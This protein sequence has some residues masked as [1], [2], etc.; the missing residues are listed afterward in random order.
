M[1]SIY[2]CGG[3]G[4]SSNKTETIIEIQKQQSTNLVFAD[5]NLTDCVQALIDSE[6]Y[7]LVEQIKQLNCSDKSI[8][9]IEGIQNLSSL[10]LLNL[11]NNQIRDITPISKLGRLK[12]L[13][14]QGNNLQLLSPVTENQLLEQVDISD[15]TEIICS[16]QTKLEQSIG[17]EN[18][19]ANQ[20]C[21]E[22]MQQAQDV[23]FDDTNLQ[24]CIRQAAQDIGAQHLEQIQQLKCV[25]QT[26]S[27][28]SGIEQLTNLRELDLTQN[29]II[30][31]APLEDL[32]L[33]KKVLLG[34]NQISNI[35][36]LKTSKYMQELR[37][38]YNQITDIQY[39]QALDALRQIH[40]TNNQIRDLTPLQ[41]LTK[42][43]ELRISNNRIIDIDSLANLPKLSSLWIQGNQIADLT[44]LQSLQNLEQL[45][46][47]N[48]WL[49]DLTPLQTQSKLKWLHLD[50]TETADL[51]PL[52]KLTQLKWLQLDNTRVDDI[53]AIYPLAQ[54]DWLHLKGNNTIPCSQL[55]HM[56]EILTAEKID[57]PET[58]SQ[59]Q[60]QS[61]N[62]ISTIEFQD[63]A[64][65]DCIYDAAREQG[66]T[67]AEELTTLSCNSGESSGQITDITG[68]EQFPGITS[69]DLSGN[70]HIACTQL[71]DLRERYDYGY[72]EGEYEYEAAAVAL[73][74][75]ESCNNP[76]SINTQTEQTVETGA[77][78]DLDA[79]ATDPNGD[80]L[81]YN[82]QQTAGQSVQLTNP[83]TATP[84]FTAPQGEDQTITFQLTVTDQYGLSTTQTI[85]ILVTGAILGSKNNPFLV[86]NY[87]DLKKVG[88]GTDGWNLDSYYLQ[89]ADIDATPSKT[90][91]PIPDTEGEYYGF[92]PIGTE[93]SPFTG[94]YDGGG[95][96]IDG[97]TINRSEQDFVGL[98]GSAVDAFIHNINQTNISVIG[99]NQVGGIVGKI[100]SDLSN[101]EISQSSISGSVKGMAY[102]GC[103][104][105]LI[106]A[107]QVKIVD[108]SVS[109]DVAGSFYVGGLAGYIAS[110]TAVID[111]SSSEGTVTGEITMIGGL[112][113]ELT[114]SNSISINKSY[115]SGTIYVGNN[116]DQKLGGLFGFIG[117]DSISL[118][119]SYSNGDIEILSEQ[120]VQAIGGIIGYATSNNQLFIKNC[121]ADRNINLISRGATS[122]GGFAGSI[123][124][125]DG[126]FELSGNV[127]AGDVYFDS[128]GGVSLSGGFAGTIGGKFNVS[129]NSSTG[130]IFI[131]ENE[132]THAQYIGGHFGYVAGT[133]IISHSFATGNIEVNTGSNPSFYIGGFSG[134]SV[135]VDLDKVRAAGNL[136]GKVTIGGLVGLFQGTLSESF[137]TG[138]VSGESNIGGLV[139]YNKGLI[140]NS[141]A[142]GNVT[143]NSQVGGLV[144]QMTHSDGDDENPAKYSSITN[145]YSTGQILLQNEELEPVD[146]GGL[147]GVSSSELNT[148]SNSFWDMETSGI[149]TSAGGEPKTSEQLKTTTTF[150]NAG[151]DFDDT[152][153]IL[154]EGHT[155]P[156][157]AWNTIEVDSWTD[158][159]NMRNNLHANYVLTRDLLTTD[160]DYAELAGPDANEGKGWKPVGTYEGPFGGTFGGSG[161]TIDGL[162][163][164]RPEEDLIGM[165][166]YAVNADY[167]NIFLNSP[168]VLG[169]DIVGSFVGLTTGSSSSVYNSNAVD[170]VVSG[171]HIVGGLIGEAVGSYVSIANSSASSQVY[172]DTSNIGGL[173]GIVFG[174][175]TSS[176][177]QSYA[178]GSVEGQSAVGGLAGTVNCS[179]ENSYSRSDVKAIDMVGGLIGE[180]RPNYSGVFNVIINSYSN[181][182]VDGSTKVGG[183]VGLHDGYDIGEVDIINSFWDI[184]TSG[185]SAKSGGTGLPTAEMQTRLT[186]T[187]AGWDFADVW[188]MRDY[189]EFQ[190]DSVAISSIEFIDAALRDCV[191]ETAEANGWAQSTQVTNL[192]CSDLDITDITGLEQL[193]EI[194]DLDLIGNNHISCNQLDELQNNIGEQGVNRPEQCNL[195]PTI[196]AEEQ[197]VEAGTQV[198]LSAEVVDPN[199]DSLTYSWKQTG[200]QTVELTNADTAVA[201]FIAPE[202]ADQTLSFQLTA[203]DPYGLSAVESINIS[204]IAAV[205]GTKDNPFLVTSYEDLKKVG[206][207]IDGWNLDSHYLQ[208]ADI[209]ASP[210]KTENL[211]PETEGEYYGF[212]PIG[213]EQTPFTGGY[214]GGMFEI[215]GLTIRAPGY[216]TGLFGYVVSGQLNSISLIDVDIQGESFVAG[217]AG[218]IIDQTEIELC[219]VNGVI[220]GGSSVGGIAGLSAGSII[221]NCN[222]DVNIDAA[223]ESGGVVG[224][225]S[226]GSVYRCAAKVSMQSGIGLVGG[227]AGTA[228]GGTTQIFQSYAKGRIVVTEENGTSAG[229]VIGLLQ[230]AS[231]SQSYFIGD[232]HAAGEVGG[233]VGTNELA[234]T[235]DNSYALGIVEAGVFA[236]GLV[237]N[238][239]SAINIT[240][241]YASVFV[242]ADS[243]AGGLIGFD[244]GQ[245]PVTNSFWNTETSKLITSDGGT[246]QS[247]DQMQARHIYNIA[248]WD[249]NNVWR[250]NGKQYP[251]LQWQKDPIFVTSYE[252]LKKIGNDPE[253]P[254]DGHYVQTADI[255]AAVSASEN[256]IEGQAGG[257]YGFMPI[258]YPEIFT[259]SYD[260]AGF[261][262]NDLYINR[263]NNEGLFAYVQNAY[264]ANI[265]LNNLVAAYDGGSGWVAGLVAYDIRSFIDNCH[266]SL[267]AASGDFVGGIAAFSQESIVVNSSTDVDFDATRAG[268][269]IAYAVKSMIVNNSA[270][271]VITSSIEYA[272]GLV[273]S[274][275]SASIY[276]CDADVSIPSTSAATSGGL[277]GVSDGY[278]LIVSSF[279]LGSVTSNIWGGGLVGF[280][281]GTVIERSYATGNV[282]SEFSGGL[283]GFK[284]T[285]EIHKSYASGNVSG[286]GEGHG[287]GG[288]VGA[289]SSALVT[290]SYAKGDVS[291]ETSVAGLIGKMTGI[292]SVYDSYSTGAVSSSSEVGGL[293]AIIEDDAVVNNSFWDIETSGIE[294]SAGGIGLTTAEMQTQSTFTDAEWDFD[295]I[296]G[297]RT[298][299]Y[300]FLQWQKTI[301]V[302]SYEDLKK[303][304]VL[305]DWPLDGNYV[306]LA[307]IDASPSRNENDGQGFLPI[308]NSESISF[309]GSYD[310]SGYE[311]DSIYINRPDTQFVGLFGYCLGCSIFN[312]NITD[313]SSIIGRDRTGGLVGMTN[314]YYA[315]VTISNS[316]SNAVVSSMGDDWAIAGGLIGQARYHN[317][318]H[319]SSATGA[320][321]GEDRVGGLIGLAGEGSTTVISKCY[322]TGDIT[323]VGYVGGLIG[324]F[325]YGTL[326]DSYATGNVTGSGDRI[327][328]LLG[329]SGSATVSNSYSVGGVS[330]EMD[331]FGGMIGTVSNSTITNSFW[332]IESSGQETSAGG[333][334]L[335]TFEMQNQSSYTE[336]DFDTIWEI[337]PESYPVLQ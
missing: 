2:A 48:N 170:A 148:V 111:N 44:P 175:S 219:S 154:S 60:E 123:T 247:T 278:G 332:D 227:I 281:T 124:S 313:D 335:T 237:G 142:R 312:V 150:T 308:G 316:T 329:S 27:N 173:I 3:G 120:V 65:R 233:L 7:T 50:G 164:N 306:Q 284:N 73:T 107:V 129:D 6:D 289:L 249:F 68:L 88:T 321:S 64:L 178:A 163:I 141:Y 4:E 197:I 35:Q 299:D 112:V 57:R 208:T 86:T 271:G 91:N 195:P 157:L 151:W 176:I 115:S 330:A 55:D 174:E 36:P 90:E 51:Q 171:R 241:S 98:F 242:A 89:T 217:V 326:T 97:L 269:L 106:D 69:I 210:S 257:Y 282:I 220:S 52:N 31:I 277:V 253:W 100:S 136:V 166:G 94:G 331:L 260:G 272:G 226:A 32:A 245:S 144:G 234:A 103:I 310:G 285:G 95:F 300:P 184:E 192:N 279:S 274:M 40:L 255:D 34:K 280:D 146:F 201:T 322:A 213:T 72:E 23:N 118:I 37:L 187:D 303:I 250:M 117:G 240:N 183:L 209:D 327:G 238:G 179:V 243:Q 270:K 263:G 82:W 138:N 114:G 105:G 283:I 211:I 273:G 302:T 318:I 58:C 153:M 265:I 324:A 296:W 229:G 230:G 336:W 33:L 294:V 10:E 205:L 26:I 119:D 224:N 334:G 231:I 216:F 126:D 14:L 77:Q 8:T 297:Y 222:V 20:P 264:L 5:Q 298:D 17:E 159:N 62:P 268:G 160:A 24:A 130:N 47:S 259:G 311:I 189:P 218:Y 244:K 85:N 99:D 75:P 15:N 333:I 169:H 131:K 140:Y 181:G 30:D 199:G 127:A 25:N 337:A 56:E 18:L 295:D 49:T 29:N 162:N 196:S 71:D 165:F 125:N 223:A 96:E 39:V 113:G 104:S 290:N 180:L 121:S 67:N 63:Q 109:C 19:T 155:Y 42:L 38:D 248:G 167:S 53:T 1:L 214:N 177:I 202:E 287:I 239:Y 328:G 134:V 84:S 307:D 156:R 320:V 145:S 207:G 221:Q 254:L 258:G 149:E 54:L 301:Y 275:H 252:D 323:G 194:T 93:E 215:N 305:E 143:G 158:L 135:G 261:S 46:L 291:G 319:H 101:I 314:G 198:N 83:N 116:F 12:Q 204:V 9:D 200:G 122:V 193:T 251:E 262:I 267:N 61:G 80:S 276:F 152:W 168:S 292:A 172:G 132:E 293:V 236:G 225:I 286:N 182:T 76:P 266:V 317:N 206:T 28:I 128:N 133:G 288:L 70:D 21:I 45:W 16:E 315:I 59:P 191:L 188:V 161:F 147:V 190:W 102:V 74:L 87:E 81:T 186:F 256:P 232:V 235:I 137:S 108:D 66:I 139:G 43:L 92:K 79:E 13:Y 110:E 41:S 212:E 228:S 78:V 309:T 203:T 11:S 185:Q 22:G 325:T 304:G 246:A